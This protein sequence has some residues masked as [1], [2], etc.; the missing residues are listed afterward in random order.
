MADD[1]I[2]EMTPGDAHKI[3]E[4]ADEP[5]PTAIEALRLSLLA[6]GYAPLPLTGKQ[7]IL[8][9][10]QKHDGVAE[11]EI[12]S[13]SK[14]YPLATNTGILTA[15]VPVLD[16]DILDA[17]AADAVEALARER[18]EEI[19]Y[20]LVRTGRFPKR[21]IPFRCDQ[22][23]AKITAKLTAPDGSEGQRIE[24]MA[25]GQ[26]LAVDGLH[27]DTGRPYG[28]HGGVLGDVKREDLPYIHAEQAQTLI[29]DAVA[30]LVA[31]FAYRRPEAEASAKKNGVG[32]MLFDAGPADWACDYSDHD[33]LAA[34][35]MRLIKS[36][37]VDGAC[38]N[39]LRAEV[40]KA[41]P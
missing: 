41:V 35:A 34:L 22:P 38:V 2:A 7:P 15:R 8:R 30:L 36:G 21:A 28:W 31:D 23:F 5:N 14:R 29:D 25:D 6:A 11:L 40:D 19:G 26:Q 32:F 17:E 18:F 27:P 3:L 10:W 20:F 1:A 33:G 4:D 12:A 16:V 24:M 37:M 9:N 13:W 39:F